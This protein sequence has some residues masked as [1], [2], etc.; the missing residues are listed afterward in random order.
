LVDF[1]TT[2]ENQR[3]TDMLRKLP[4]TLHCFISM[5]I[6]L[7]YVARIPFLEPFMDKFPVMIQEICQ[8]IEKRNIPVNNFLF[9]EGCDGFYFIDEGIVSMDGLVYT[10]GSVLGFTCLRQNNKKIEC[11]AIMDVKTNFLPRS[12]LIEILDRNP[13]V[14]YYCMRWTA[15]EVLRI[16]IRTYSKLYYTAARRGALMSPPLLSRRPN[17]EEGEEDDIDVAVLDHIQE[18]GF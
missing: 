9:E 10:S 3:Q 11:R 12:A 16:Y 17:M 7:N 13:K 6:Y 18:M 1:F 8:A 2:E 5:E 14:K 15:W 4:K